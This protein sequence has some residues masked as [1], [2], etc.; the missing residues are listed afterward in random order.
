ME[1]G[2]AVTGGA[3]E[4]RRARDGSVRLSGRFPYGVPAVLS[5][6]GRNGRP[7]KELFEPRAFAHRIETPSSHDGGPKEIHLLTGHDYNRPLASVRAGTLTLRDTA[8]AVLIQATITRAIAETTH[9]RDALAMLESGLQTGLS[10]GF[11]LPPERA[12][13]E[14]E[15]FE[16]EEDDGEPGID[17]QPRRGAIIR[18]IKAALLYEF[19]LVTRPAYPNA[20]IEEA[21]AKLHEAPDAGLQRALQ[22]WRA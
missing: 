12:V 7:R 21:R 18:R 16:Q 9:G 8:A 17:G 10:P 4:L 1:I 14:P 13:P 11:R 15:A 6:G 2:G 19:S 20:Q 3:L 22:R 5:D